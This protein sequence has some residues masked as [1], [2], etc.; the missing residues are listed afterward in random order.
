[1]EKLFIIN[2]TASPVPR[3]TKRKQFSNHGQMREPFLMMALTSRNVI[4]IAKIF[5]G[6]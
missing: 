6:R 3:D 5:G 4:T 2:T 1:M